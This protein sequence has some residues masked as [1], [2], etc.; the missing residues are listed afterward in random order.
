MRF[1][2]ILLLILQPLLVLD[3][4][5][6]CES[7]LPAHDAGAAQ[8]C[9]GPDAC[10]GMSEEP[11]VCG[12]GSQDQEAPQ[13]AIPPS[14]ERPQIAIPLLSA[15]SPMSAAREHVRAA[16]VWTHVPVISTSNHQRQALLS[17]WQ[18]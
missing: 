3:R 8:D 9:C 14:Q 2:L 17:I 6:N 13:P 7:A 11:S 1:L 4:S 12:C 16:T 5:A 10:C 15:G 18:T